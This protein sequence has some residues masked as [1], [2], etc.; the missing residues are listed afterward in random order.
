MMRVNPKATL[1]ANLEGKGKAM[2]HC[3]KTIT[4]LYKYMSKV[5][6]GMGETESGIKPTIDKLC[7]KLEQKLYELIP[8][9]S[10]IAKSMVEIMFP[11]NINKKGVW[12]NDLEKFKKLV[13]SVSN[14]G[15]LDYMGVSLRMSK[16]CLDRN[17]W[18]LK[19]FEIKN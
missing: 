14:S 2:V 3:T 9:N 13:L 6:S 19:R 1:L 18:F 17:I 8:A 10:V 15:A 5:K 4:P 11:K 12:P 7:K 16:L